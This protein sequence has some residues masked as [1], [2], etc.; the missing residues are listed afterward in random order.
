[1]GEP[2]IRNGIV[3]LLEYIEYG[4]HTQGT[5]TSKYLEEQ[6]AKAIS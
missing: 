6:K 3:S 5:E 2:T 4:R 1:M